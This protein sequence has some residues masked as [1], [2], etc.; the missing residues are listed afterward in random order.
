MKLSS[1]LAGS[2]PMGPTKEEIL[3]MRGANSVVQ[4]GIQ[5]I[6]VGNRLLLVLAEASAPMM[7]RDLASAA[8]MT[9]SKA[10]RYLV[11]YARVGL[12]HQ[13]A[14]S[15]RYDLGPLSLQLGF[16]ALR[17]FDAIGVAMPMLHDLSA[18][19][20]QTVALAAWANCGA[21][22][23]RWLGSDAPVTATLRV[24][25]VMPLT[26]SATGLV[27]AAHLPRSRWLELVKRELAENRRRHLNPGSLAELDRK[28]ERIRRRGYAA[29]RDFI[30]G[31]SGVAAPVSGE[32]GSMELA[33][34]ALG[35][36]ASFDDDAQR[37]REALVTQA[38]RL[39]A[40]LGGQGRMRIDATVP[41]AR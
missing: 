41:A 10:H 18:A 26:R 28:L 37:I 6:E 12:V 3:A 16:A 14:G 21:T 40:R 20:G 2:E 24:G 11:S 7:L 38:A 36:S 30:P 4:Q 22:I 29:V 15:G 39:S 27:F 35:H 31:I 9:A 32:D 1:I 25:S 34:V 5:S 33:M 23:V 19:I 8:G 17:R 13:E